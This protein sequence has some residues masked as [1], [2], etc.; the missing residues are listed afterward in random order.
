MEDYLVFKTPDEL[1]GDEELPLWESY[2]RWSVRRWRQ[3]HPDD[4]RDPARVVLLRR[5]ITFPEPAENPSL[6]EEAAVTTVGV[7][8][9]DGSLA[10]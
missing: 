6:Y 10:P 8:H 3:G 5:V 7:F 9:P 1:P 2:A 4:D